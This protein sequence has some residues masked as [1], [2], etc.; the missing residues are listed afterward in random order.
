[1][2]NQKN[3]IVKIRVY[4]GEPAYN[5]DGSLKTYSQ[6]VTLEYNTSGWKLFLTNMPRM[7]WGKIEVEECLDGNEKLSENGMFN[8]PKIDI[9]KNIQEEIDVA[10]KVNE[11]PLTK[12][13]QRIKDLEEQVAELVAV[14][15]NKKPKTDNTPNSNEELE[16]AR[17]KYFK[18]MKKKPHHTKNLA[19]LNAEIEAELNKQ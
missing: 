13:E 4:N 9:P 14:S 10:M 19:K 8:H 6:I 1:M 15:K 7:G 18:V 11:K 3:L 5:K 12:E 16:E 17:D 2:E